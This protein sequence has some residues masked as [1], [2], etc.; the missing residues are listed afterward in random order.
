MDPSEEGLITWDELTAALRA[1]TAEA[2]RRKMQKAINEDALP[3]EELEARHGQV[4][5][6]DELFKQFEVIGFGA[7]LV[8][9][10][11]RTDGVL[12]SLVF[13]HHP[14]FYWGFKEH[15]V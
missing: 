13:Q 1:E 3:R 12:G 11:R 7:P 14:R 6:S 4:W 5:S 8:V 9:A 2:I 10:K 15:R